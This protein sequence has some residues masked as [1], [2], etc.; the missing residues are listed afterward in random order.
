MGEEMKYHYIKVRTNS[1]LLPPQKTFL[2]STIRGAFGHFLKSQVCFFVPDK[3]VDDRYCKICPHPELC[4]FDRYYSKY[5]NTNA[6]KQLRFDTSLGA[7]SFDFGLYLFDDG[8]L[9]LRF[10]LASL[11]RMLHTPN[12]TI[13]NYAF[14]QSD[15]FLNGEKIYFDALGMP[16]MSMDLFR[17]LRLKLDERTKPPQ[18]IIIKLLSPCVIGYRQNEYDPEAYKRKKKE[19]KTEITLEDMIYSIRFRKSYYETQKR[20]YIKSYD[21]QYS[22]TKSDLRFVK[23]AKMKEEDPISG[24]IGEIRVYD[25]DPVTYGLLKAG[26]IIGVGKKTVMGAGKIKIEVLNE[27]IV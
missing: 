9:S 24:V 17:P 10:V 27:K 14:A 3:T 19:I 15:I 4:L 5:R 8:T 7:K 23:I 21:I 18:H 1:T 6:P 16:R 20:E 12:L 2:G 13:H 22:K 26:E 11:R 25:I